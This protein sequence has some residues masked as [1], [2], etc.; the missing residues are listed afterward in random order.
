MPRAIWSGSISFGLVSV[1][2]KV[3]SAVHDHTVHFHQIDK[4]TK[5][6]IRYEKVSDKSGEEVD[7][8]DI[9]LGYEISRGRLIIV[10]PE[11]VAEL[12]PRTTRTID[13]TD[14][15]ELDQI[16]PIYYHRTY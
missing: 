13:V 7:S 10:D 4:Q 14:F 1:A 11:R 9:E 16:D 8:G 3:Y 5:S 2:V 6:R 12:R 15:V